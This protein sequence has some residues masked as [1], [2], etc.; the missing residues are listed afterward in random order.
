MPS[1]PPSNFTTIAV[2]RSTGELAAHYGATVHEVRRWRHE[3]GIPSP[4]LAIPEF[5]YPTIKAKRVIFASDVHVPA[6]DPEW[7][8]RLKDAADKYQVPTVVLAGDVIDFP[9]LSKYDPRD[10]GWRLKDELEAAGDVLSDLAWHGLD[11]HWTMGNHEARYFRAQKWQIT[12]SDLIRTCGVEGLVTGYDGEELVVETDMGPW[13]VTHPGQYNREPARTAAELSAKRGMHV[14]TGH[15]HQFGLRFAKDGNHL[16]IDLGGLFDPKGL[17]YLW[18][19]GITTMP[20]Q[21]RGFWVV[22][23]GSVIPVAEGVGICS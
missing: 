15:S 5:S 21:T 19:G 11:V 7:V 18:R 14:A 1:L 4:K 13:L 17:A 9:T 8:T 20:Q 3:T 6:H 16:A 2:G 12:M 23:G 22:T 10:I